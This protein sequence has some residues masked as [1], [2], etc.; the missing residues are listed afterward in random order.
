MDS[1][2][3]EGF[4]KQNC[5]KDYEPFQGLQRL[6]HALNTVHQIVVDEK[7]EMATDSGLRI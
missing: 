2:V 3:I 4:R 1:G 5:V 7:Y 6:L